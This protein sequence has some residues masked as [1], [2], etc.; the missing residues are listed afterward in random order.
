MNLL[1]IFSFLFLALIWGLIVF[2]FIRIIRK[3]RYKSYDRDINIRKALFISSFAIFV[4]STYWFIEYLSF[5]GIL[6][7]RFSALLYSL[8]LVIIPK[9]LLVAAG[10]TVVEFIR[11]HNLED[12]ENRV[13]EMYQ[14][15][16]Y[17]FILDSMVSGVIAV[18]K[19]GKI[20]TFN[21]V[22]EKVFRTKT[23]DAIGMNYKELLDRAKVNPPN[24]YLIRTL[25][26]GN[27]NEEISIQFGD[28]KVYIAFNS[29][30]IQDDEGNVIGAVTV[31]ED[32][33][34]KRELEEKIIR[35][36]KL[37]VLGE[38]AAG[39]AHEIRNPLTTV[40]G[41]LQILQ[42]QIKENRLDKDRVAD[43]CEIM[44]EEIDRSN[45]IIT[46]FLLTTKPQAPLISVLNIKSVI[47]DVI[48]LTQNQALMQQVEMVVD[49]PEELPNV[50]IDR[51][52]IKQVFLNL[53]CNAF[54]A[55][56]DGGRLTIRSYY[57]QDKKQIVTEIEDTGIGIPKEN[58]KKIFLPF[59]TSKNGNSG[60][61]G[62]G[63]GLSVCK[64]II[65]GHGGS[66]EV[67]SKI[68]EGSKF[69]VYL[70]IVEE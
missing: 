37:S 44:L 66:I 34:A 32:I 23:E 11:Q 17:K 6:N 47:N 67:G 19:E 25:T 50:A 5:S 68:N 7:Y 39:M 64:N 24:Y 27:I 52:Q 41:F 1:I 45:R 4:D 59:F 28:E 58:L 63:L 51:D 54:E 57:N 70:P 56:P 65:E 30:Q 43:Y 46:E 48:F 42:G 31:F 9:M 36:E 53:I 12:L 60:K 62:T 18:N 55:M 38:I 40:K 29:S 2:Y 3:K 33:T 69:L 20:T 49:V 21:K 16:K 13:E 61:I 26:E 35:Y 15:A 10:I 14:N 8:P 22:A